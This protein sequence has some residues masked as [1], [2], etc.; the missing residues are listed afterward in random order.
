[1]ISK[2]W[3]H[4]VIFKENP[5]INGLLIATNNQILYLIICILLLMKAPMWVLPVYAIIYGAHLLPYSFFYQSKNYRYSSIFICLAIL[6]SI[7]FFHLNMIF[8]PLIVE[9]GVLFLFFMLQKEIKS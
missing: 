8:V 2:Q 7:L 6:I 4:P 3:K 1:M 5:L 9:I